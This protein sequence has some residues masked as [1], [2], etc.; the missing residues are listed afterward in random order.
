M[1]KLLALTFIF[2]VFL[3]NSVRSQSSES[4]EILGVWLT[5]SKKG[6]VEI[7]NCGKKYCGKIVWLKDPFYE[8][9]S[10]KRDKNNPDSKFHQ[11][12]IIGTVILSG[13]EYEEDYEW[14]DGTIYDPDN[15]K[16]YSCILTLQEDKKTLEVRGYVGFSWI[17]RTEY[18]TASTLE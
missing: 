17:G 1:K 11:R 15:G 5:G 16:T 13:F 7:Y 4:D 2:S 14:E 9:G 6:K 18:W 3:S 12:K 10:P 8:D